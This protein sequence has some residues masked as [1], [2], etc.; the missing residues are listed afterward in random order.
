MNSVSHLTSPLVFGL[1]GQLTENWTGRFGLSHNIYDETLVTEEDQTPATDTK[2]E[3]T[4][5]IDADSVI[6]IGL[7]YKL[8]SFSFDWLGNTEL[9][10]DGPYLISGTGNNFSTSFAVTYVFDGP[11]EKNDESLSENDKLLPKNKRKKNR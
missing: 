8:G 7:S 3:N 1:Q 5:S 9:F 11:G 4:I 10:K 2:T 6:T